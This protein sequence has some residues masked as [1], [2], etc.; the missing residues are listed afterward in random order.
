MWHLGMD[1]AAMVYQVSLRFPPGARYG[2]TSQIQRAAISVPANV[3]EGK[4]RATNREYAHFVAIAREVCATH[5]RGVPRARVGA[6]PCVAR[7][8]MH[9]RW[10]ASCR[11]GTRQ[12]SQRLPRARPGTPR[13]RRTA[14]PRRGPAQ[15]HDAHPRGSLGEVETYLL[16][17]ERFNSVSRSETTPALNLI[18][19]INQMLNA[20]RRSLLDY[21]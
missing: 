2:M 10:S 14:S 4:G 12:P 16:L 18:V 8:G 13:G 20:L 15:N 9:A 1:L 11:A 19:R 6:T 21:L 5:L 3:A 17:A 7:V